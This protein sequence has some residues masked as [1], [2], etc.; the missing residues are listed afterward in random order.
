MTAVLC[1]TESVFLAS[2][3]AA[4]RI[5]SAAEWSAHNV[6]AVVTKPRVI[7]LIGGAIAAT[8]DTAAEVVDMDWETQLLA[9][10]HPA[11]CRLL[12]SFA[13]STFLVVTVQRQSATRLVVD[14]ANDRPIAVKAHEKRPR[15][16][17]APLTLWSLQ[18]SRWRRRYGAM[19][20]LR[21]T[22]T[23]SVLTSWALD[24]DGKWT[25]ATAVAQWPRAAAALHVA[26]AGSEIALVALTNGAVHGVSVDGGGAT[27]FTLTCGF[28]PSSVAA[29]PL[30]DGDGCAVYVGGPFCVASFHVRP[31][32]QGGWSV[33]AVA[34]A[35]PSAQAGVMDPMVTS[36]RPL[37]GGGVLAVGTAQVAVLR[38]ADEATALLVATPEG[39]SS[40]V[41]AAKVYHVLAVA[42]HAAQGCVA[43]VV[44]LQKLLTT[45][46]DRR[47]ACFFLPV[48]PDAPRAAATINPFH[49][50]TF[51]AP[52]TVDA[53]LCDVGMARARLRLDHEAGTVPHSG[54]RAAAAELQAL[55][56]AEKRTKDAIQLLGRGKM[57]GR[58]YLT[59]LL[60]HP[61]RDDARRELVLPTAMLRVTA[62]V[63]ADEALSAACWLRL[64]AAEGAS[65]CFY[66]GTFCQVLE[67]V[68][69]QFYVRSGRS[70]DDA[71]AHTCAQ[72][73]ESVVMDVALSGVCRAGHRSAFS[74]TTF[75][76]VRV[77]G[78]DGVVTRCRGCRLHECVAESAPRP[79]CGVCGGALES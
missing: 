52:L 21:S 55:F 42:P 54:S 62:D 29:G 4:Q 38:G 28:V 33:D 35:L 6:L 18:R 36:L 72:C 22:A 20:T 23:S 78:D 77:S 61:C 75:S 8:I 15:G 47:V 64:Y 44:A 68:L 11:S 73:D 1:A 60:Q 76:V 51:A 17:D 31:Q 65:S 59:Q 3:V 50:L 9:D 74:P 27:L 63:S 46:A 37:A 41:A 10:V 71:V 24:G 67:R 2:S 79:L 69:V 19:L 26:E 49:D 53:A 56:M 12:L 40:P 16:D 13:D 45:A 66:I 39:R 70:P 30:P 25:A 14:G 58:R 57:Y 7:L 34:T 48:G 5:A 32:P 43:V